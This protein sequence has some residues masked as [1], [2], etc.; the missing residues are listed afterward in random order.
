MPDYGIKI[1]RVGVDVGTADILNL[2]FSSKYDSLKIFSNGSGSITVP[3]ASG[4]S[5][6]D[7]TSSVSY[8]TIPHNLG[9]KPVFLVFTTSS[10][11]A[12]SE[13]APYTSAGIDGVSPDGGN[14]WA[15]TANIYIAMYNGDLG[16]AHTYLYR[17]QIYYNRL[18]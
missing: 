14:Y 7:G 4:T 5:I 17:Y 10:F 12:A 9:Y 15:D 1:S 6:F 13:F 2:V 8:A 11:G 3:A 16:S 18:I